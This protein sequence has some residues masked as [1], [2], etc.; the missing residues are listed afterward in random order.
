MKVVINRCYGGF[1][2]SIK[3]IL[4]YAEIKGI[5]LHP[6]TEVGEIGILSQKYK[7]CD[8]FSVKSLLGPHFSTMPLTADGKYEK[9]SYFSDRNIE[10]NDPALVQ[11]VTEL[12]DA[13]NGDYAKLGIVEIP[14]GISYEISDYDGL[15]TV[16]ESHRSWS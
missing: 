16:E 14:D 12:G 9:G 7:A 3:A 5:T 15:E 4:R 8:P 13:A 11:V 2:L 6:F 1:G 10:R